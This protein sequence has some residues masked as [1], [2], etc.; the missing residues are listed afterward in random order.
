MQHPHRGDPDP[1]RRSRRNKPRK[2]FNIN[3]QY[4]KYHNLPVLA[5]DEGKIPDEAPHAI[6]EHEAVHAVEGSPSCNGFCVAYLLGLSFAV[7]YVLIGSTHSVGAITSRIWYF[8]AGAIA[9]PL[10]YLLAAAGGTL[11]GSTPGATLPLWSV[12]L[13]IVLVFVLVHIIIILSKLTKERDAA[14]ARADELNEFWYPVEAQRHEM[15]GILLDTLSALISAGVPT[16]MKPDAAIPQYYSCNSWEN[17]SNVPWFHGNVATPG[18]CI[19]WLEDRIQRLE[20][21]LGRS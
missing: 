15:K 13:H 14:I 5:V 18:M 11:A 1:P 10:W 9:A 3:E 19:N 21:Q 12:V 6:E 4:A 16:E 7:Y 8:V 2:M 20:A 17:E